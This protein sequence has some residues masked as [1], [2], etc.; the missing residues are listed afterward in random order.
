[1]AKVTGPLLALDASGTI[2]KAITF[3]HW[4]GIKVV[5][6]YAKPS[7][8][9]SALQ[10]AH[11]SKWADIVALYH[12]YNRYQ[13]QDSWNIRA[14]ME[15]LAMTGLNRF[16]QIFMPFSPSNM[17][18][19]QNTLFC[20]S[21]HPDPTLCRLIIYDVPINLHILLQIRYQ[22]NELLAQHSFISDGSNPWISP[23][24]P[25]PD[26]PSA[27]RLFA[28]LHFSLGALYGESGNQMITQC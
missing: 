24:L 18:I 10:T 16:I 13:F 25:L 23:D 5:K 12:S 1:M 3:S 14:S 7:N 2:A 22:T 20:L 27:Y 19:L 15:G 26:S 4:K 9:R 17:M 21:P 8:P 11:R 28:Q 6:S